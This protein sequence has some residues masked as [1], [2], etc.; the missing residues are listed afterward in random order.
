MVRTQ[1]FH[2]PGPGSIPSQGTKIPQRGQKKENFGKCFHLAFQRRIMVP[3]E[4]FLD[5]VSLP[6]WR[7]RQV[8]GNDVVR[9]AYRDHGRD[10]W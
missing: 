9:A 8:Q 7:E 6:T 4:H 2:C 3:R 5:S 10:S 1:C